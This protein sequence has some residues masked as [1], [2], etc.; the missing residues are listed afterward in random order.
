MKLMIRPYTIYAYA[1]HKKDIA[2][3]IESNTRSIIKHLIKLRMF[4]DSQYVEHWRKEVYNFLNEIPMLKNSHKFPSKQFILDNTINLHINKIQYFV[5]G[6]EKD[7][8]Y[9]GM[10]PNWDYNIYELKSNI[11]EYFGWIS[12]RLSE[13]GSVFQNEVFNKLDELGF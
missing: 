5:T 7:S 9:E 12:E 11:I 1:M 6:I 8:R 2:A 3:S 4:K 10:Y 13:D